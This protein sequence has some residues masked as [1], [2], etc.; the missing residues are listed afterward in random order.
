[1]SDFK[2]VVSISGQ[3]AQLLQRGIPLRTYLISS[4]AKGVGFENGSYKTPTGLFRIAEKIGDR[5]ARGTVFRQR[6]A[7]G[8]VWSKDAANPLSTSQDDLILTRILWLEGLEPQNANT[9]DRYIYLH[10]T[11]QEPQLGT[12]VSHGCIRFSNKDI[13]DVFEQVPV[14]TEVLIKE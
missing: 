3:K 13:E 11:N 9:R 7:T 1:M 2:I 6:Q 10:G 14:G 4:A 5:A 12:P 8:E